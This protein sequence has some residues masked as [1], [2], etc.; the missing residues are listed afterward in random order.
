MARIDLGVRIELP[1]QTLQSGTLGVTS[2]ALYGPDGPPGAHGPHA[3][4]GIIRYNDD[5]RGVLIYIKSSLSGDENDYVLDYK[6]RNV[7]F[8]HETTIDQ[9]FSEEQFEAYRCL[10]FHATHRLH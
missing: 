1:W 6:R 2:T 5:E 9:F 7:A 4:I 8:P 3:G 10:G